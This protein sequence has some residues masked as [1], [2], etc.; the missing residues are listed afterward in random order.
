MQG[1]FKTMVRGKRCCV[2]IEARDC[3]YS[4]GDCGHLRYE[5]VNIQME[6]VRIEVRDC[7]HTDG[8]CAH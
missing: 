5:I 4:G 8:D 2:R 6:I 7:E 3:A 1:A